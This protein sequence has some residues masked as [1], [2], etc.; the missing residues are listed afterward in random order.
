MIIVEIP[1]LL[2]SLLIAAIH[3][4]YKAAAIPITTNREP[5]RRLISM[6]SLE[7]PPVASAAEELVAVELVSE[8]V[9]V[10]VEVESE[11]ESVEVEEDESVVAA[12]A[13]APVAVVLNPSFTAIL[14]ATLIM[15]ATRL[16]TPVGKP[17]T[18]A[19]ICCGF[20]VLRSMVWAE[21]RAAM[22]ALLVSMAR[23]A[24]SVTRVAVM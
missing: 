2:Q 15:L 1:R 4:P 3:S 9:E 18:T 22:S 20:W 11:S 24:D 8:L 7:A 16:W 23:K 14:L 5:A 17:A 21:A 13:A 19:E 12:A 10:E 6:P